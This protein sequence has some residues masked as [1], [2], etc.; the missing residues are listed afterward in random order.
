MKS[1]K[2]QL[3]T[4][5]ATLGMSMGFAQKVAHVDV[6][7][8]MSKMPAVIDAQKQLEKLSQTYEAES[9][10]MIDEYQSKLKKYDQ[11]ATTVTEKDNE[12]RAKELQEM[13]KRIMDYRDNAQKELQKKEADLLKPITEK[14]K[15]SIKKVGK[16]KGFQYV[17]N[18]EGLLLAEGTN[19]TAD[20]K[21]DLGF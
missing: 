7:E 10:T 16:A 11:E 20:V 15:A 3:L 1:L 12:D 9:K 2:F 13:Q 21:K 6:S 17:L 8:I 19:I 5:V 18:S 4:L 14:V